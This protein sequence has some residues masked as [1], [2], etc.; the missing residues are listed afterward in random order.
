MR[1][2][3]KFKINLEKI[4]KFRREEK[5]AFEI[6]KT[7][8][9]ELDSFI[10]SLS[11]EL[12]FNES[13]A[14]VATGGYGRVELCPKSDVDI[15]FLAE[16]KD[17]KIESFAVDLFQH[18]WD[19]NFNIGHS[20]RSIDE[21]LELL[22]SD[23]ES[24]AS[25][26]ESRFI[27][28]DKDLYDLFV[29]RLKEKSLG[30]SSLNFI[31]SIIDGNKLRHQK[32]GNTS[33]LLEPNVKK[34]AGGLRDLHTLLWLLKSTDP[35]FWSLR[36]DQ[37]VC[38]GMLELMFE[39]N[40]ITKEKFFAVLN[41]FE[42][43]LWTRIKLH[44]VTEGITDVL[45]FNIKEKVAFELGYRD[46]FDKRAVEIFMRDYYLSAREILMLNKIFV[47]GFEE[48]FKPEWM[49]E[50]EL[51]DQNFS[52]YDGRVIVLNKS[53]DFLTP[54]EIFKAFLYKCKTGADFDE[55]LKRTIINSAS[56]VNFASDGEINKI[57]LE[58]L[59]SK[60][61][62]ASTLK[63]MHEFEILGKYIPGFGKLTG[64]YQH[65][66]Y[67]Y[68]TVDEHT[69]KA[70]ENA[71]NLSDTDS[72]LGEIFRNL[73]RRDILY[74]SILFHDAGKAVKV[75]G[76]SD[77]GAEIARDFLRQ[78]NFDAIDDVCFLVKN[79]LLMEQVAFRRNFYE[80]ETLYL[81]ASNFEREEQ[82]DML[83]ILTYADLSAVN[84][85]VW[86]SWKSQL[87]DE[88][89]LF[90]EPIIENRLTLDEIY[91]MLEERANKRIESIISSLSEKISREMVENH[92]ENLIED[93][94]YLNVFSDTEIGEHIKAISES[95]GKRVEVIFS[96]KDGYTEVTVITRDAPF[97]LAKICGVLSANDANIFDAKI[98]TRKDGIVIDKFRVF[99]YI[100]G[101]ELTP[102]QCE[103]IK[104]DLEDVFYDRIN[105][106]ELFEKHRRK[107][108]RKIENVRKNVKIAVE[109][110]DSKDYT[111]IDV[112]APDSLGFLYKVSR[113]ISE[114]GLNIY[115]AKIATRTDG[116]VDSF[117]VL[118]FNGNKI[119]DE[120]T[121][122][123]I[124]NEILG[125]IYELN[126]LKLTSE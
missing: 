38:K 107:W 79:H 51:L 78:I 13:F 113:K 20:Y 33:N 73:R 123:K 29:R 75:E 71:E 83:Y 10:I 68:F 46:E 105:F 26:L 12:G 47:M 41:A 119:T 50:V 56:K 42:F 120:E 88:L 85:E 104:Q 89:Y 18:L 91:L 103:K 95:S 6:T 111:I 44:L 8:T 72:R 84:P 40:M 99:D 122:K 74:L 65:N 31:K 97:V 87:L 112:F 5:S 114:L 86:T 16:S 4:K 2:K 106:D 39:K 69:L 19:V 116:I 124:R 81:F 23:A 118:D 63:L 76:H 52:I 32:Y 48:C 24:W 96:H 1:V 62:V 34:S 54:E 36:D 93:G 125:V 64:L 55:N 3:P 100:S 35:D 77:I 14:I 109:F 53:K 57:F 108:K 11:S 15:M 80:P 60:S 98:F 49:G 7:L 90:A 37:S 82:L 102:R 21:C 121:K 110:E 27:C 30:K 70:I 28:G 61:G 67:H 25:L 22:E 17:K 45:D 59:N 92:F 9:Q 43:L 101:D 58:I 66:R 126:N 117:Y 94:S 115:F